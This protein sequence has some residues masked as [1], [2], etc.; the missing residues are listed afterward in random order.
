MG[1]LERELD[2]F[3]G[4]RLCRELS[5]TRGNDSLYRIGMVDREGEYSNVAGRDRQRSDVYGAFLSDTPVFGFFRADLLFNRQY[6]RVVAMARSGKRSNF[7]HSLRFAGANSGDRYGDDRGLD[8]LGGDNE[9]NSPFS[10]RYLPGTRGFSLS[11]RADDGDEFYRDGADA[12]EIRGELVLLDRRGFDRHRTLSR[13]RGYF[14]L[15]AV[16]DFTRYGD[17]GITNVEKGG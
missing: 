5:R 10:S 15:P 14:S 13:E 8:G 16:R 7:K 17:R 12:G 6:L 11:R 1:I 4:F 3:H 9:P 2:R